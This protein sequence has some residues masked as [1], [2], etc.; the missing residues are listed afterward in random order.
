MSQDIVAARLATYYHDNDIKILKD[1][2]LLEDAAVALGISWPN[3]GEASQASDVTLST[4]TL[5]SVAMLHLRRYQ[6]LDTRA[7]LMAAIT[8][9]AIVEDQQPAD[10]PDALQSVLERVRPHIETLRPLFPEGLCS[11]AEIQHA[12]W[13]QSQRIASL[14][15]AIAAWQ[16]AVGGFPYADDRRSITLSNLG[17]AYLSRYKA[18]GSASDLERADAST[19][20]AVNHLPANNPE[21]S[22]VL[23]NRFGVLRALTR[24]LSGDENAL[25]AAICAG[26][27]LLAEPHHEGS[28]VD[29]A[30][31]HADQCDLMFERFKR[32]RRIEDLKASIMQ[33]D[34]A[35]SIAAQDHRLK[36]EFHARRADLLYAKYAHLGDYAALDDAISALH[37]TIS[38]SPRNDANLA[39]SLYHLSQRLRVRFEN[40][41][42]V[43]DLENSITAVRSALDLT[44]PE[45]PDFAVRLNGLGIALL[46]WFDVTKNS[47]VLDEAIAQLQ[48][49][50]TCPASPGDMAAILSN[51]GLA[52]RRRFEATGSLADLEKSI[53]AGRQSIILD[54]TDPVEVMRFRS[55]LAL[56][57][58]CRFELTLDDSDIDSAV[59]L[60][61][62]TP[63]GVG[64]FRANAEM[65]SALGFILSSRY[66]ATGAISDI[67][68]AVDASNK[69]LK[70]AQESA[71]G[72]LGSFLLNAS[73]N[74]LARYQRTL[75]VSD[76]I[77]VS[78]QCHEVV[79][80]A[81][82]EQQKAGAIS[83]L[84]ISMESLFDQ[85][86]AYELI[87]KAIELCLQAIAEAKDG[88]QGSESY[89][90]NL[91]RMVIRRYEADRTEASLEEAIRTARDAEA[92]CTD[93]HPRKLAAKS[94]LGL[95][96][97][98]WLE[99]HPDVVLGS[100]AKQLFIEVAGDAR[101]P[102]TERMR[103]ARGSGAVSAVL[104]NWEDAVDGFE[105]A[106]DELDLA[107]WHGL[108]P[109][110]RLH[111]VSRVQGLG[112]DATAAA[113]AAGQPERALL[114]AER[115]RGI[116]FGQDA[117]VHEDLVRLRGR[118]PELADSLERLLAR[119]KRAYA[120]NY[121]SDT[122]FS[123][124][125]EQNMALATEWKALVAEADMG[126]GLQ[127]LRSFKLD[128][129]LPAAEHG[130]IAI[131]NTSRLR[132]DALLVRPEGVDTLHLGGLTLESVIDK[133]NEYLLVLHKVDRA[134]LDLQ[135]ARS[136]LD[137][138]HDSLAAIRQYTTAKWEL[139]RASIARDESLRALLRWL[140][141]EIAEPVL[142]A[143]GI[144]GKPGLGCTWPRIWWCPTGPI[145]LLPLHAAG[146][147]DEEDPDGFSVLDRAVSSYTPTLRALLQARRPLDSEPGNADILIVAVPEAQ[148][149]VP[150][151]N[152]SRE[153]DFLRSLF[154]GRY[155]LLE[156][157]RATAAAVEEELRRHRL[158]H[159]A[160]HGG[161][162]LVDPIRGGVLLHDGMLT[163]GNIGAQRY[164]GELA[165]LSACKTAVGGVRVPD[166]AVTLAAV[167]Q[168]TG[169][170]QV[171]GT[172]WSVFDGAA[173]NITEGVYTRLHMSDRFD[174]HNAARALHLT[175]RHLRDVE[176][177]PPAVW[178]PFIHSGS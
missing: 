6:R 116:V 152:V 144:T 76:L 96:L 168:F 143:L 113:I 78:E 12:I 164:T 66:R 52:L 87:D 48:S 97:L 110:D 162:D 63:M 130:P 82:S 61:T 131:L 99:R 169:Y 22:A 14:D 136:H 13:E 158:A 41:E 139:Q 11:H 2:A 138:D 105:H 38:Q 30:Q 160:C 167:L 73:A 147:Y 106:L 9:G 57:L 88:D 154:P 8:F 33:C 132:C 44:H 94:N 121:T 20:S 60:I 151:T 34:A 114:M 150:L 172:M 65:M 129:L 128:D 64:D 28:P 178:A 137:R 115:G 62:S 81:R 85:T 109:V 163:I 67:N 98:Y 36:H 50:I 92:H 156:G 120:W 56:S 176:Q 35:I 69:A 146:Y 51:L 102:A 140:W 142:N 75:D 174:P 70:L 107:T 37:E 173:A 55:N 54:T 10:V 126:D 135:Q 68:S 74:L 39:I 91:S 72:G 40:E 95:S 18:I 4:G 177:L 166:E 112:A 26:T 90:T 5:A 134:V 93:G 21:R 123:Y 46:A 148:D 127:V 59:Q 17:F 58:C 125:A 118:M 133:T 49:G 42:S 108:L 175:I 149:E 83:N 24:T 141:D 124:A 16:R 157:E 86:G 45:D 19:Q 170:Q 77:Q 122:D 7:D 84:A 25:D 27:A 43:D 29:L 165:F 155:T 100:E 80:T 104:E 32:N 159:F 153:R 31:T 111:S 1:P 3:E 23:F 117:A 47:E 71:I 119:A 161:Q 103:A 101:L 89:W 15:L 145:S 79:R 171:I 53:A